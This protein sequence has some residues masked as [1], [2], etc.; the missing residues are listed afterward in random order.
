MAIGFTGGPRRRRKPR[1]E[2]VGFEVFR[3]DRI[4]QHTRLEIGLGQYGQTVLVAN[5]LDR[6]AHVTA[7]R[8]TFELVERGKRDGVNTV[9]FTEH[10]IPGSWFGQQHGRKARPADEQ[11][12]RTNGSAPSNEFGPC[13][14]RMQLKPAPQ[15]AVDEEIRCSAGH[16]SVLGLS[17]SGRRLL[18][19]NDF[20][21]EQRAAAP[22]VPPRGAFGHGGDAAPVMRRDPGALR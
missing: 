2:G 4:G 6:K 18:E 8:K 16:R 1:I 5:D 19:G 22:H 17:G 9:Q 20:P 10:T 3:M 14:V 21:P 12:I 13:N 15:R 11:W 7:R